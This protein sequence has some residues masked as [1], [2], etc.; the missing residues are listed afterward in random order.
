M[1]VIYLQAVVAIPLG[2]YSGGILGD[3]LRA[4]LYADD[5]N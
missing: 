4:W 2:Y 1:N 3:L 5:A